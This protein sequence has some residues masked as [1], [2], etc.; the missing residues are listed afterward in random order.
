M[1]LVTES[2][3]LKNTTDG[4]AVYADVVYDEVTRLISRVDWR[5]DGPRDCRI[6]I[7]AD[8]KPTVETTCRAGRSGGRNVIGGYSIDTTGV[9][10]RGS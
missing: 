6:I 1:A 8:G 2:G 5:N 10:I 3:G 4:T 7:R 9:E